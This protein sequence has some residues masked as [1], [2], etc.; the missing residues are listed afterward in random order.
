MKLSKFALA[1]LLLAFYSCSNNNPETIINDS[2]EHEA[3]L[4]YDQIIPDDTIKIESWLET[5]SNTDSNW[6]VL[7]EFNETLDESKL[8]NDV[9][10]TCCWYGDIKDEY[11]LGPVRPA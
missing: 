5:T 2:D 4:E 6:F 1:S 3:S 10:I 11:A 7:S 9:S 8:A